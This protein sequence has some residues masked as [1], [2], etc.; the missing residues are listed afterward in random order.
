MAKKIK[1]KNRYKNRLGKILNGED[2]VITYKTD[3]DVAANIFAEQVTLPKG[4]EVNYIINER[5]RKSYELF[6]IKKGE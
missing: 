3:K 5:L 1:R 2:W 4:T 6:P